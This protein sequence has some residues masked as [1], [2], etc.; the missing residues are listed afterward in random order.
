MLAV[1]LHLAAMNRKVLL[2]EIGTS[3]QEQ[4]A[5]VLRDCAC[6]VSAVNSAAAALALLGKR[7]FVAILVDFRVASQGASDLLTAAK[8]AHPGINI[9]LTVEG[10]GTPP[11]QQ[12][13]RLRGYPLLTKPLKIEELTRALEAPPEAPPPL[14]PEPDTAAPELASA[15]FAGLVGASEKMKKIYRLVSKVALQRHPVL[16]MGES[17]TGK[18]LVARAIHTHGPWR[19]EPFVPVDC[20]ALPPTLIES[21]LFGHVKGAFTG[22]A[23]SRQGLLAAGRSGTVFLDEIGEL[24]IELQSRLL[25]ALQEHEIRPL[26]SNERTRFEARIIAATNQDLEAGI[27]RGSFR[28]DLF[29]RLNVVSIKMPSLR[30]RKGDIPALVRY[31]LARLGNEN[32]VSQITDEVL[33][34]MMSYDWPGNVR[35]LENCIQRAVSLGSGTFIQMQDLPSA[36][37]YHLARK[38]SSRQDMTTL[39]A[40]EQQAIRQALEATGG[41]R[42]RAAKLLGIGKTT[43][44]RKLKEYG[45]DVTP[46]EA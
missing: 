30:D 34:R 46:A 26:G 9:I 16:I 19:D 29:F 38:S 24:P 31:F 10:I 18:E 28:K 8:H 40:I 33:G 35:E 32:A 2:V 22:A 25:R 45:I 44:Y 23:Q 17:G 14:P 6:E 42:V 3:S 5:R 36:M 7:E 12:L 39:Q 15:E 21:E 27:K 43:I 41:D 13:L 1:G 4:C 37:L 11:L 20:G